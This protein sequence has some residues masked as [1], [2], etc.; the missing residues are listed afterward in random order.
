MGSK[1]RR[2]R[3]PER[4]AAVDVRRSARKL[5]ARAG[6][7]GNELKSESRLLT[8]GDKIGPRLSESA[9][10]DHSETEKALKLCEVVREFFDIRVVD[11]LLRVNRIPEAGVVRRVAEVVMEMWPRDFVPQ[12]PT[13]RDDYSFLYLADRLP[14][15]LN[16]AVTR[17]SLYADRIILPNH[18]APSMLHHPQQ[19]PLVR[20]AAWWAEYCKCAIRLVLLEPWIRAGVVE[21]ACNPVTFDARLRD[22]PGWDRAE[23]AAFASGREQQARDLDFAEKLAEMMFGFSGEKRQQALRRLKATPQ[24]EEMVEA[25]CRRIESEE[26][27]RVAIPSLSGPG[28]DAGSMSV[29]GAGLPFDLAKSIAGASGAHIIAG[30]RMTR[31]FMLADSDSLKSSVAVA[32][33]ALSSAKLNF[34]NNVSAHRAVGLRTDGA[35]RGF[36]VFMGAQTRG[37]A[38]RADDGSFN[39]EALRDFQERFEVEYERY[40][41]EWGDVQRKLGTASAVAAASSAVTGASA[42]ISGHIEIVGVAAAM[43]TPLAMHLNSGIQER[44]KAERHPLHMVM[45]LDRSR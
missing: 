5:R 21:Q 41:D 11:G 35:L 43:L 7:P 2:N 38:L 19:S 20:P 8:N 29:S 6:P 14:N 15:G 10:R 30:D 37:L 4:Q 28:V 3:S 40:K 17:L 31:D 34:L 33:Q 24:I 1:K 9:Y 12:A 45:K 25:A 22:R 23:R 18:F 32:A 36:R 39:E 44:K 26:P 27:M 42:W 16:N 13:A